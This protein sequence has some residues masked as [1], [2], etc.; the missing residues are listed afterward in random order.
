[1]PAPL[2][3]K[4]GGREFLKPEASRTASM[5]QLVVRCQDHQYFHIVLLS[6]SRRAWRLNQDSRRSLPVKRYEG[7]VPFLGRGGPLGAL[8]PGARGMKGWCPGWDLNH[9]PVAGKRILS[10]FSVPAY[11]SQIKRLYF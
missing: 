5:P 9:T 2:N 6:S 1:M 11:Y 8:F 10:P 4:S 7:M 3:T